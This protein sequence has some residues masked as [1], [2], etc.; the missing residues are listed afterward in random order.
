MAKL[1]PT[2]FF[3]II[4]PRFLQEK[5]AYGLVMDSPYLKRMVTW[6]HNSYMHKISD[7][8]YDLLTCLYDLWYFT[9]AVF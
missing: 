6:A 4:V 9:F 3:I 5:L 7:E 2:F 8:E 1:P